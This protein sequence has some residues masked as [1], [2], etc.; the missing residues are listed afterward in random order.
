MGSEPSELPSARP[1]A[2]AAAL[3]P[4]RA[5]P[6]P[7]GFMSQVGRLGALLLSLW[8]L[9][10]SSVSL[11]AA[12]SLPATL[13]LSLALARSLAR[14]RSRSIS[15]SLTHTLSVTHTHLAVDAA[16]VEARLEARLEVVL[17]HLRAILYM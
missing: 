15:L 14:S 8:R 1:S 11:S 5:R 2:L 3:D 9:S 7:V 17:H 4:V 13:S 10:L 12:L 16:D 6:A